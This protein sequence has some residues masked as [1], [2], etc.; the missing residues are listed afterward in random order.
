MYVALKDT[1]CDFKQKLEIHKTVTLLLAELKLLWLVQYQT[2][3]KL[4]A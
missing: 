4:G 3:F 2:G 1:I